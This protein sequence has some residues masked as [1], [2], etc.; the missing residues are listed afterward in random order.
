M[1]RIRNGGS[2]QVCRIGLKNSIGM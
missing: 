1:V 2:W